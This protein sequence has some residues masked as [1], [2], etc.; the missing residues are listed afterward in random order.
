M[1]DSWDDRR[2][3]QE[4]E[5]FQRR[6]R[7]A[8]ERLKARG[9]AKPRLSPISGEAMTQKNIMGIVVDVCPTSGGVWLDAGELEQ[10]LKLAQTEAKDAK[11]GISGFLDRLLGK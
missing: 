7:E 10:L 6:D 8:I 5:Y 2:R 11:Q 4:E 9:T 3:A 1:N